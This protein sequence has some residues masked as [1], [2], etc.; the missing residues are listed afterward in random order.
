V[1]KHS[2]EAW[3]LTQEKNNIKYA[4]IVKGG[5]SAVHQEKSLLCNEVFT[6]FIEKS[7]TKRKTT[8]YVNSNLF[9]HK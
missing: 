8:Y 1:E 5:K 7:I 2:K 4:D 3:R 6:K 9:R